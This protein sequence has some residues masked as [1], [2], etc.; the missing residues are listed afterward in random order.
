[1]KVFYTI[2]IVAAFASFSHSQTLEF[3]PV[4]GNPALRRHAQWEAAQQ[5]AIAERMTGGNTND[6][7]NNRENM[8]CPPMLEGN[9]VE[10]GSELA[11]M[12]DTFDLMN[13]TT[14]AT[15]RVLDDPALQFGT[16]ILKDLFLIYEAN[17]GLAGS[18][19][20][21]VL[22][23]LSQAV[24]KDT[25]AVQF[26]IK[27][28]GKTLVL[29]S[30]VV[31]P[32]S[33][34]A[35]C[36]DNSVDF[37]ATLA[38]TQVIGSTKEYDGAGHQLFH[39][40][41][42]NYPDTCLVY[43]ASRFPGND[44]V[45]IRI[46]DALSVCDTFKIPFTIKGDTIK[47]LP[48]F[49][50]FSS[51]VGPYA[52]P[53]FWL[54]KSAFVNSTLAYQPPSIGFAT[55][56]GLDRRGDPYPVNNGVGDRLTSKPI[57]LSGVTTSNPAILR[58]FVAPK[59]Y[60]L[61]PEVGDTLTLQFRNAQRHWVNVASFSGTDDIPLDS[62]PPFV[63]QNTAI[64]NA[65][66]LHK[67]F[68][69]RFVGRIS[70]GGI[71]DL[72]HIDYVRLSVNEGAAPIFPDVAL[73]KSPSTVLNNYTSMPWRHFDGHEADEIRTKFES[74]FYNHFQETKAVSA[75]N[76]QLRETT[77]GTALHPGFTVVNAFNL[78]SVT[79]VDTFR[80]IDNGI[81]GTIASNLAGI[82]PADFRNVE[83]R[84]VINI[85]DQGAGAY[86]HN[87]TVTINTPFADYFSHDDGSAEW[88]VFVRHAN[89]GEQMAA[90]FHANVADTM[91]AVQILFPHVNGD[92]QAQ[93][94]NLRIWLDSVQTEPVFERELLKPFF[95]S[96]VFDTLQGFTTYRL[97]D[98]AGAETPVAIPAGRDFFVG[99]QQVTATQ[100]GIPVGF[101]V[102]NPCDCNFVNLED[103]VWQKFPAS[104]SGS[105]M[106]RPV[107][108]QTAPDNTSSGVKDTPAS[109]LD[110]IVVYPNPSN[111]RVNV[112][113]DNGNY[114]DYLLFVLTPTG[115]LA[116]Q[117]VL[118]QQLD[119]QAL[120]SGAYYLQ[121]VNKKTGNTLVQK[122]IIE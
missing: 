46:C 117:Q 85:P 23:E 120:A 119:L 65:Q 73:T 38:C 32:E 61:A 29:P 54:D 103:D 81:A 111:G 78:P 67:A 26:Q 69:F 41:N 24:D 121:F 50:D 80:T 83:T 42:Y 27:R 68:Q 57:D 13:D 10:S 14:P 33:V 74:G 108:S 44:T 105:L 40:S 88:Q 97:E 5:A 17:N 7:Q 15:L 64:D 35:R 36:F 82:A 95:A 16:A 25:I 2:I 75:S 31:N 96:N 91:R 48:F 99:W 101:D 66:F 107:F 62:L 51:Y 37:P 47:T 43:Y 90:R 34:T 94:F 89:G 12:L 100:L 11:V 106:I 45:S 77:T 93:V 53:K 18:A 113:L 59:G 102:Q 86:L 8:D 104:V 110:P 76:I 56:D 118:S 55:L 52:S 6:W 39:L 116:R 122:I 92:I 72:W 60:G 30:Q 1:M 98:F 115:Q 87:D 49:D 28:K 4:N 109:A 22:V 58:F 20:E 114:Q 71:A 84:Y 79:P 3:S 9:I 70:P 112:S 63:F 21:T 19:T